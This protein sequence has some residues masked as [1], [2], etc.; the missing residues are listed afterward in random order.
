MVALD[1][2]ASSPQQPHAQLYLTSTVHVSMP[3][4]TKYITEMYRLHPQPARAGRS[5]KDQQPRRADA[6]TEDK[7]H[8]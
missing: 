3:T 7:K 6:H 5:R 4:F 2:T 8:P 1:A